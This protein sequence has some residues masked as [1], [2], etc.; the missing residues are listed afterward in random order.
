MDI[1]Q[2]NIANNPYPIYLGD[3]ILDIFA[4]ILDKHY[5]SGKIAII[6]TRFSICM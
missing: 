6:T 2:V 3:S 5:P 1:I 4:D